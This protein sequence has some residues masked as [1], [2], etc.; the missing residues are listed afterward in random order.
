[1]TYPKRL[2][3]VDLPIKR[4]PDLGCGLLHLGVATLRQVTRKG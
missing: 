2:N 3:E 1:M 4:I